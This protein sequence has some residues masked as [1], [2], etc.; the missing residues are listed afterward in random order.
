[1]NGFVL[2]IVQKVLV[3]YKIEKFYTSLKID[4]DCRIVLN[5]DMPQWQ[6]TLYS[7][8]F[9]FGEQES[10]V[11]QIMNK[12]KEM[13]DANKNKNGSDENDDNDDDDTATA[14]G[15]DGDNDAAAADGTE[16]KQ[17][18]D[19]TEAVVQWTDEITTKLMTDSLEE[20]FILLC[21]HKSDT[22]NWAL[23]NIYVQFVKLHE[24]KKKQIK[25]KKQNQC[26]L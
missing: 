5:I 20:Y 19:D 24:K 6:H 11:N 14:T 16:K 4:T 25:M 10:I 15:G 21:S 7:N 1:M 13:M 12:R 8:I 3:F 2:Y 26:P 18:E 23:N 17:D 9:H 22:T